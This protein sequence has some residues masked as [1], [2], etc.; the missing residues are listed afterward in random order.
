MKHFIVTLAALLTVMAAFSDRKM[1]V[2]N[3]DTGESFDIEVADGLRLNEVNPEWL[4]S[5]PYLLEHAREGEPWARKA[6]AE[7]Y[8]Y[9]KG[10]LKQS[11]FNALFY[12]ESAGIGSKDLFEESLDTTRIDPFPLAIDMVGDLDRGDNEKVLHDID[13]LNSMGYHSA[14]ILREII[15]GRKTFS[16]FD[17]TIDYAVAENTD[18]D[19]AL[20]AFGYYMDHHP[21]TK[22][23]S[24]KEARFYPVMKKVPG[25]LMVLGEKRYSETLE[26]VASGESDASEERNATEDEAKRRKAVEYLLK[27]D[28]YGLLS[29][30]GARIIDHYLTNDPTSDWLRLSDADLARIRR[31]ASLPG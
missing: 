26:P 19:A 20:Y 15:E 17:E 10:G 12:Y 28:E 1:T 11:V 16:S 5:V 4:D 22:I 29:P 27:A 9:G 23:D 31:L 7:C 21:Q 18:P 14:D 3:A 25:L 8:R 2:R 24:E 6:I 30:A 13:N